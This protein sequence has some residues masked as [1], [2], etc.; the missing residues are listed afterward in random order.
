MD[1]GPAVAAPLTLRRSS[2]STYGSAG[3]PHSG[4]AFNGGEASGVARVVATADTGATDSLVVTPVC[5]GPAFVTFVGLAA[6]SFASPNAAMATNA[7]PPT[8]AKATR[9]RAARR[10]APA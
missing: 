3:W 2:R 5:M 6:S 10:F 1:S 9:T 7:Q 4:V 8:A